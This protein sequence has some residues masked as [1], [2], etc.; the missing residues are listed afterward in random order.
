MRDRTDIEDFNQRRLQFLLKC[1]ELSGGNESV[2]L[3]M[4]KV[5]KELGFDPELNTAVTDCLLQEDLT[6]LLGIG[7]GISITARGIAQVERALS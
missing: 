2:P 5:G 7:S 4:D 3:D 6:K 1:H